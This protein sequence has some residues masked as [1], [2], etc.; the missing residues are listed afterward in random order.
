MKK[1]GIAGGLGPLASVL[2]YERLTRLTRVLSD[3][4]HIELILY[5]APFVPDRSA[6]L[7]GES[8]VSPLPALLEVCRV[9][10]GL[11]DVIAMPCMTAHHF[12][13]EIS[14]SVSVPVMDMHRV[15]AEELC[16]AGV[17]KAGVLATS[18]TVKSGRLQA[19]LRS[20]GIDP[21]L[22][23]EGAT[24]AVMKIIYDIKAGLPPDSA[25][26]RR[27]AEP[28]LARGAQMIL[29]ACTELSLFAQDPDI[30]IYD[31]TELLARRCITTVGGTLID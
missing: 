16:G 22:P 29:L 12:Y 21:V 8:S 30:P 5:S 6:F 19:T 26:F 11:S 25:G 7:N 10:E 23:D 20:L 1:L 31:A 17:S 28:L 27:V 3:Q 15:C 2:F 14:R 9:L 18:G 4:E 13:D 24:A